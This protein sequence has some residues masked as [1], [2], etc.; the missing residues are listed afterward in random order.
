MCNTARCAACRPARSGGKLRTLVRV[1]DMAAAGLWWLLGRVAW[2]GLLLAG[3]GAW[4]WLSGRTW[5][6]HVHVRLVRREVR[7]AGN[8]ALTAAVLGWLVAPAV[9]AAVCAVAGVGLLAAAST[10]R[11]RERLAL[12][13]APVR[14][15]I[16]TTAYV[17]HPSNR[18]KELPR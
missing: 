10:I 18:L 3:W 7:A 4:V 11:V 2:P 5:R 17:T 6:H 16:R 8:W 12:R 9:T 14:A 1:V 13:Q 15:P